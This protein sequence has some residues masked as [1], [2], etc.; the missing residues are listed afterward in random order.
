[1]LRIASSSVSNVVARTK[2]IPRMSQ[3]G[4]VYSDVNQGASQSAWVQILAIPLTVRLSRTSDFTSPCL[5]FL[6][7]KME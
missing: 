5:S 2:E 6:N 3:F 1:M 4:S 7:R